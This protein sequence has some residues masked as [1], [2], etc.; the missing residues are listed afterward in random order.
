MGPAANWADTA[1][2]EIVRYGDGESQSSL[3]TAEGA[4]S[5]PAP[6]DV[7]KDPV[8]ITLDA[9]QIAETEAKETRQQQKLPERRQQQRLPERAKARAA[10][11]L[12]PE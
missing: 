4:A 8:Q 12:Q 9:A 5:A 10:A 6:L 2:R 1:P 7:P 11:E 3:G